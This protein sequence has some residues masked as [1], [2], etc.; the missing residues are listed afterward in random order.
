MAILTVKRWTDAI[1]FLTGREVLKTIDTLKSWKKC[2][3]L[4]KILIIYGNEYSRG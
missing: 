2:L 4:P 1:Q 3:S